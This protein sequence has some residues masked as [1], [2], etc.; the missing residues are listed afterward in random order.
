[1]KK[2]IFIFI[3]MLLVL[4]SCNDILNTLPTDRLSS[5]TYW[6]SDEDAL[7]ACNAIYRSLQ[8]PL[9]IMQKDATTDMGR[10]TFENTDYAKVELDIADPLTNVFQNHWNDMYKG[11]SRCNDYLANIGKITVTN[12]ELVNQYTA[13]V[14]T[15]RAY[16]YAQLVSLFGGVP[17]VTT[18]ITIS[19]SKGLTRAT[20]AEIYDF[21]YKELTE[22]APN[23]PLHA[24]ES[25]RV[26]RG[27]ALGIL[28]RTMLFASGNVTGDDPRQ[29]EYLNKAKNAADEVISSGAYK[30]FDS[31]RDLFLYANEDNCEVIFDVEYLKDYYSNALMNNWGAVS[32]GNNGPSISISKKLIDEYE[33]KRGLS[34]DSD[35][36]YDERHPYDNRDPR[37]GYSIY[38]PGSTLVDGSTY[39]PI[40]G[41]GTSDAIGASYQVSKTGLIPRKYINKEDLGTSNKNNCGINF[42]IMRYAEILL[43]AA[44]TR[45][46]LN[47]DLQTAQSYINQ[48]RARAD[49][50]MPPISKNTQ[51]EL[52]QAV[53]HERIVE[54][55]LEGLHFYDVRR[56]KTAESVCTFNKIYGI[57]YIDDKGQLITVENEYHKKFSSRC[58]LWPI[59]YNERQL[60]PNLTQN[61]GWSLN[62]K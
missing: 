34:I 44:E 9:T 17:L 13:E 11:I 8:S 6:K 35:S 41:S 31:Y 45:I 58:Y 4:S 39:N 14:R 7:Y 16:F 25:G 42:I 50:N 5:D 54:L 59:P 12:Q 32:L 29:S 28:A 3:T 49:V 56:W 60:N 62:T 46:E 15:L 22:A 23:L 38:Y 33:T 48:I 51:S 55:A 27:A 47:E 18:P 30:L 19:E 37:L 57:Q 53:R 52:R 20:A 61:P 10:M 24:T 1:M 2:V 21:I 43:I 36:E 40:P 26:T